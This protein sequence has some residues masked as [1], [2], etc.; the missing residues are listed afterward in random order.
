MFK[1]IDLEKLKIKIN[2]LKKTEKDLIITD[3]DDTLFSTKK[4]LEN[5]Y[6]KWR[7]WQEWNE[8]IIKHNLVDLIIEEVYKSTIRPTEISSKLRINHDLI[9]TAGIEEFQIKKIKAVNLDNINYRIVLNADEKILETILYIIDTLK[10]IP[11]KITVYEDRPKY[12]IE[13]KDF[14]EEF[15][16]TE[17]EIMFVEMDWNKWYKQIKKIEA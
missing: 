11:H 14:L 9:L 16:W 10:F 5:D 1:E 17:V 15:L 4:L 6:R 3:F 13:Y 12:F 2:K 8:Y 7:R